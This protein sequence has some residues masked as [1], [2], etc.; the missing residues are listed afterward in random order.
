M[1]STVPADGIAHRLG[2]RTG[3]LAHRLARR[4]VQEGRRRLLDHLLVPPLDRTF[5]LVQIDAVAMAVGQHLNLDMPG[6]RHELS[7]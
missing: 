5:P 1:N 2:Q 7:Q 3:L 4:R 6:L